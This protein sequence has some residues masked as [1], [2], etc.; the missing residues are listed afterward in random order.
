MEIKLSSLILC[1]SLAAAA[2]NSCVEDAAYQTFEPPKDEVP[3]GPVLYRLGTPVTYPTGIPGLSSICLNEKGDGFYAA[4][5]KG[6][7]YEIGLDG[8][9][10]G[11]VPFESSH[12]W[13]G[14][15]VDRSDGT[16]YL[17]EE[18]EWAV[19]KLNKARNGVTLVAQID[20]EG[21]ENNRGFEGIASAPG[22]LYLANQ[23]K[24]RRIFVYSLSES[25]VISTMDISFAKYL[26]DIYYDNTDGSL[27][28]T[29]SKRRTLTNIKTDGTIIGEY[30]ISFVAKP[31]GFCMNPVRK[32]FWFVCDQTGNIHSIS[33]E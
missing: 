23:D 7:L 4:Y 26:S 27:W 30:D 33:Y 28:I 14:V 19:Y 10:K 8:T 17:C 5:D 18:R 29:D 2:L 12:D 24:P 22:I 13:E 3:P 21:G 9:V 31:E 25:K 11:I 6:K 15:T 32:Q 20:V 16:V 1:L